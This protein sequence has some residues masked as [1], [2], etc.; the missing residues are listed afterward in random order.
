[1]IKHA[2]QPEYKGDHEKVVAGLV[3]GDGC[4]DFFKPLSRAK[5]IGALVITFPSGKI[6]H[7]VAHVHCTNL[8]VQHENEFVLEKSRLLPLGKSH[9]T[10]VRF[11]M[12]RIP[13]ARK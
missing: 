11:G 3:L 6:P 12:F 5:P 1:L 13:G 2:D 8:L 7:E 9:D 10:A 4:R